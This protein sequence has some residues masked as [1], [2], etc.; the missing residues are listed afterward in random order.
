MVF[1]YAIFA[2]V[3]AEVPLDCFV[4]GHEF[5][6][7]YPFCFEGVEVGGG[8][9]F[10]LHGVQ[11]VGEWFFLCIHAE[12]ESVIAR[13][14]GAADEVAGLGVRAGNEESF[15]KHEIPLESGGDKSV[16]VFTHGDEYFAGE[17][18][19]FLASMELVFK[20]D[21]CNTFFREEFGELHDCSKPAMTGIAI[22]DDGLQVVDVGCYCSFFR[23]HLPSCVPLLSVME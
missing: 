4:E 23:R 6:L 9:A 8:G 18:A 10:A 17:V 15:G 3:E 1:A 7:L 11:T 12:D 16:D 22:C 2:P 20:V 19:T 13:V 5:V 21:G 14:D